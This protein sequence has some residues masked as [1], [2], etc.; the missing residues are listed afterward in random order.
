M[1]LRSIL[2]VGHQVGNEL[3]SLVLLFEGHFRLLLI[4]GCFLLPEHSDMLLPLLQPFLVTG[5]AKT[6]VVA[7]TWVVVDVH[8]VS[9]YKKNFFQAPE[10]KLALTLSHPASCT[11]TIPQTYA[12][13]VGVMVAFSCRSNLIRSSCRFSM[14]A[15][16]P[17]TV[18]LASSIV[19]PAL[20]TV[21]STKRC[22]PSFGW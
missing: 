15:L 8:S 9:K 11:S 3:F 18:F 5:L 19:F 20:S 7:S 2:V 21:W 22:S 6:E 4:D 16:L 12:P 17:R 13:L 10:T 1:L 14:S